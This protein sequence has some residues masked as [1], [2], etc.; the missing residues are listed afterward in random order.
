MSFDFP[1][2]ETP[3]KRSYNYICFP[4]SK[5][6]HYKKRYFTYNFIGREILMGYLN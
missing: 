4:L 3:I 2:M 1:S 6:F 5:D